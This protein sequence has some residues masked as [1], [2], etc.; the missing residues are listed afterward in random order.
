M[1]K[2]I[3]KQTHEIMVGRKKNK[4]VFIQAQGNVITMKQEE[5]ASVIQALLMVKE[6]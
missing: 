2:L 3:T 6:D 4:E 1:T 5:I